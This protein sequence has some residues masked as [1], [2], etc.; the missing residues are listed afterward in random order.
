[1]SLII[2]DVLLDPKLKMASRTLYPGVI[3]LPV[4]SACIWA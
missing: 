1:M 3:F 4:Y 2:Q